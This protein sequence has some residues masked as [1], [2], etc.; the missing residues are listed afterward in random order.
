[1]P[2]SI[3]DCKPYVLEA[4][5]K[6]V[7]A[8]SGSVTDVSARRWLERAIRYMQRFDF[9]CWRNEFTLTLTAEDYHYL[10]TDAVWTAA[11]LTRPLR[12]DGNSIR[13]GGTNL[14]WRPTIQRLDEELGGPDWKDSATSGGTPQY[15]TEMRQGLVLGAKPG[16][17][18][19]T[20]NPTLRGYCYRGEDLST[21]GYEATDLMMYDDFQEHL[22]NL[23]CVFAFQQVDDTEYRT[24]L[25]F[26]LN[27]DL[28][29]MRGYDH[30]PVDDEPI[31]A[32]EWAANVDGNDDA[33]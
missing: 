4:A 17:S 8:S 23:A 7:S 10:Y 30:G 12:L 13:Y 11:A 18:F 22:I 25:D 3:D 2:F 32:P 28:V 9:E 14:L 26:W 21:V 1:M 24:Q 5:H 19:V 27:R 29:E 31:P 33:Y 15:V 20:G 6:N 16:S